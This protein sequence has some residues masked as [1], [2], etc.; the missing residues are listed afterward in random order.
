M[1]RLVGALGGET[2][3]ALPV[4]V[5]LAIH[6]MAGVG[7]TALAVHVAHRVAARFPDGQLYLDLHG[8][9]TSPLEPAEALAKLLYA[10]GVDPPAVPADPTDRAG[11][12]R[13]LLARRRIV[14]VLD[15]AGSPG[16]I[17]PLLPGSGPS[18]VLVTSRTR[19][20]RHRWPPTSFAWMCSTRPS[21]S[22]CCPGR[23]PGGSRPTRPRPATSPACAG[24]FR[25]RCA[26]SLA[27]LAARPAWSLQHMA[28][29]L[30]DER[31]RLDRLAMGDLEVRASLTLSYDGLATEAAD[32]L[33]RVALLDLADY[34]QWFVAAL[35]GGAVAEVAPTVDALV[36]AQLL[37]ED[38]ATG[39][40]RYRLHDLVRLY[41]RERAV[42]HVGEAQRHD[43]IAGGIGA[44]LAVAE[45]MSADVPGPCFAVIHGRADRTDVDWSA[46]GLSGIEPITWFDREHVLLEEATRQA[47]RVGLDE[48]AYGLAAC[49]EKYFDVRGMY[50]Q[51][52][53]LNEQVAQACRRGRQHPGRGRDAARPH[54]R[55]HLARHREFRCRDGPPRGRRD[56]ARADVRQGRPRGRDVRCRRPVRLGSGCAG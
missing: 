27:R 33:G 30:A 34:P 56:P 47:C 8:N 23:R 54:R 38:D 4:P 52:R 42:G 46:P 14:I 21:P 44:W 16:Q 10:L 36:D 55:P 43:I 20:Q 2:G 53:G 24:A 48:H 15:N 5:V 29:L 40:V 26:S 1:R 31:S 11:L 37:I 51:W 7:K 39:A 6:G 13:S 41:A 18:A 12:L 28:R 19:L 45:R 3:G 22:P 35:A 25:S 32:L 49:L 17:R 50:A 9:T